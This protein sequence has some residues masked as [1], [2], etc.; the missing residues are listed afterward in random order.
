MGCDIHCYVEYRNQKN[1]DRGWYDFGGRINP[2]R[3]YWMFGAMA[4]VRTDHIPHIEPRGFPE[5][6][7]YAAFGDNTIYVVDDQKE[8]TSHDY[9][10]Y[11]YSRAHADDHA[12][13]GYCQYI[14]RNGKK[15]WVTNSDHHTHSWLTSS[16]FELAIAAYLKA[17][18]FQINTLRLP[19]PQSMEALATTNEE[20]RAGALKGIREYWAIL[21]AMRCF[22]AQGYESRLNFW[23]DN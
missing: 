21:A 13:K 5:D 11:T 1:P 12:Q 16:E 6:S 20:D 4:G 19:E 3:N 15:N 7:G 9:D 10:S 14:E 22:D 18:G 17:S 2:G 23:F 8:P